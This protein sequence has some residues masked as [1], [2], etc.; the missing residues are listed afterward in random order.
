[1]SRE[2]VDRL[3]EATRAFNQIA[4]DVV[5]LDGDAVE[6]WLGFMHPEIRF[7][8]QQAELEGTYAGR[9]GAVRWLTDIA[10]H[11]ESGAEMRYT[12][13]RDLG[14]RALGLGTIQLKGKGSGIE[15][16]VPTAIMMTFRD[17]LI[18][19]LRDYGDHHRALKA[20]GLSE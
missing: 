12:E 18:V 15:A 16:A 20:V 4:S 11:Y 5:D 1:M 7:E 8:P 13:V 19:H 14:D 6:R 10:A 17:G 2:N 3:I 9:D